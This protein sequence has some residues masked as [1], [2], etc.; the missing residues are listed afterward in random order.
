MYRAGGPK[1]TAKEI[2]NMTFAYC[3]FGILSTERTL[4]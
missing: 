1:I 4:N 2:C 3:Y